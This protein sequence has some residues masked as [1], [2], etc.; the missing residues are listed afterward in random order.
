MST[1]CLKNIGRLSVRIYRNP[2]FRPRP[3]PSSIS[4]ANTP[5]P[6]ARHMS[7]CKKDVKNKTAQDWQKELT[8]EQYYVAREGGTEPP[9]SGAYYNHFEKGV[10]QCVCCGTDLF[11]SKTKFESGCGWPSFYTAEGE[12]TKQ[13]E[14]STT[15]VETRTDTSHKMVRTEVLCRNCKAH[16]GHVFPDG[17]EPTGLRYCINSASLKFSCKMLK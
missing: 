13:D 9:F 17:P 3:R 7:S 15:L 12:A 1:T 11:S 10:Y 14:A 2:T 16:L 5:L 4:F 6:Q 8:P